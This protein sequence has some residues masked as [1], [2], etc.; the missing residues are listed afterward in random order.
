MNS[1]HG[2]SCKSFQNRFFK[3]IVLLVGLLLL[4]AARPPKGADDFLN[5]PR[6]SD[7]AGK[8]NHPIVFDA[9]KIL[10]IH[11]F[12][13]GMPC[14]EAE[15][16]LEK[17]RVKFEKVNWPR[18]DGFGTYKFKRKVT[19][20]GLKKPLLAEVSVSTELQ[21]TATM[22][23]EIPGDSETEELWKNVEIIRDY[24]EKSNGL[25]RMFFDLQRMGASIWQ[26][27]KQSEVLS[28][29]AISTWLP[30]KPRSKAK[31]DIFISY[32]VWEI[33]QTKTNAK[34][35]PP[36]PKDF[37][38]IIGVKGLKPRATLGDVKRALEDAGI[39]TAEESMGETDFVMTYLSFK[40]P[41]RF[42]GL[43]RG[44]P[45]EIRISFYDEKAPKFGSVEILVLESTSSEEAAKNTCATERGAI[46]SEFGEPATTEKSAVSERYTWRESREIGNTMIRLT[47]IGGPNPACV[48]TF[49]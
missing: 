49:Y 2:C 32:F 29:G 45:H 1:G 10:G 42:V 4:D 41:V 37:S 28:V 8:V 7:T 9:A 36:V 17:A 26:D 47:R 38:D 43:G 12:K 48:V 22:M 5:D 21:S 24:F 30:E 6:L 3:G 16:A 13:I 15:S 25:S 14:W 27:V 46:V 39:Q 18:G 44:N 33:E 40:G 31:M 35:G 23:I 34:P 20:I 11:G 19:G